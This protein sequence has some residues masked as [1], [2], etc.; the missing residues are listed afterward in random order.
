[1]PKIIFTQQLSRFTDVPE[2]E[3]DAASLRDMLEAAFAVN[4][5]LRDYVMD[6]QGHVRFHVAVFVDGKRVRDRVRLDQALSPGST[7]HVLQAL[8]GG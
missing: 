8:S 7:V 4:P 5:R 6:E 1:M 3:A 2:V